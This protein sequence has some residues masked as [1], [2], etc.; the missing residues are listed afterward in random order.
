MPVY[1][2]LPAAALLPDPALPCPALGPVAL[3]PVDG[4]GAPMPLVFPAPTPVALFP[5]LPA[6]LPPPAP[7]AANPGEPAASKIMKAQ[8]FT[9]VGIWRFPVV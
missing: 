4:P 7:L 6:P 8:I 2:L 1:E 9:R 5:A 3:G